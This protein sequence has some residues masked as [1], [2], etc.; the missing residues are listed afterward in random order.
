MAG[1]MAGEK[2][3]G[4]K[5]DLALVDFQLLTM[6]ADRGPW[7]LI[8]QGAVAVTDGRIVAVESSREATWIDDAQT[9]IRGEGRF[10]TPGLI[11]CHTHLVWGGC[12]ADEWQLRQQGVSYEEI[13]R[14]GGGILSTVAA[15]RA[16]TVDELYSA[17]RRRVQR[18]IEEG[19]TAVEIKTGYGLDLANELKMI[20]VAEQIRDSMPVD[21][22]VTLLAAHALPPEF[23]GRPDD[24]LDVV[25]GEIIPAAAGRCDAVDVFCERIAFDWPQTA[26][27]FRAAQQ[28]S[29]ELKIHAEQLSWMD[30][31]RQAA[32][33]GALSADH[34]EY[35][36]E[37]GAMAMAR[38]GTTAVLL[39]GAYWFLRETRQ[40]PIEWLR[41]HAVPIAVATDANP[42][43][44]PAGSLLLMMH[45]ACVLFGLSPEEG[46]AGI[47]RHA[48]AALGW[49][50][51]MGTIAA[52]MQAD[53]AAWEIVTPAELACG[54][55]HNPLWAVF[56]KGHMVVG[57]PNRGTGD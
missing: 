11:D 54:I 48:A 20:A 27:V 39:P 44:S 32:E 42:G 18:L 2:R 15:T 29:L 23:A 5:I 37:A 56:K 25:C 17:A 10:L 46:L 9:V 34:L 49:S 57:P 6:Q 14:C 4:G 13:S 40:P 33:M 52:G 51:R 47:T 55:G 24:Y 30:A 16:A 50:D 19:V 12:R 53:L 7:G 3:A 26:R 41:K 36:D 31:A 8:E 1:L 45:M 21:V 35:L 38:H 43:S 22:F 28:H